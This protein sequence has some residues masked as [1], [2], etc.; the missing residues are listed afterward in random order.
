MSFYVFETH[1]EKKCNRCNGEIDDKDYELC[2]ACIHAMISPGYS[3]PFVPEE[4][5]KEIRGVNG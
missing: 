3:A 5:E 1:P 2:T 4:I